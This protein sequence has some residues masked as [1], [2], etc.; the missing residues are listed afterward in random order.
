[1]T[2]IRTQLILLPV[3]VEKFYGRA[4]TFHLR[5]LLAAIGA[6]SRGKLTRLQLFA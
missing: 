6:K 4:P 3:R 1:M 2:I 5:R